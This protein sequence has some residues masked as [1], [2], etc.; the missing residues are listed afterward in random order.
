MAW[1]WR[2]ITANAI[3][4][5]YASLVL[6]PLAYADHQIVVTIESDDIGGRPLPNW[7]CTEIRYCYRDSGVP[8]EVAYAGAPDGCGWL[9]GYGFQGWGNLPEET[10]R[11]DDDGLVQ[12]RFDGLSLGKL[13]DLALT[14]YKG[15]GA[16][17]VQD[18]LVDGVPVLSGIVLS[19]TPQRLT[20]DVPVAA[21]A[22]GS[23]VV[24]LAR[25]PNR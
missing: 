8:G 17:R 11:F 19:N 23:I 5:A 21:Y 15:D 18:V 20:V 6:D 7:R 10:V 13:Y 2:G 16:N 14:F 24:V 1:S 9:D 3:E 4:P 12:Y 25:R 22:D